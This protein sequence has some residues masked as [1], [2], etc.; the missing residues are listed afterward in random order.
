MTV[1]SD[2]PNRQPKRR[3]RP[4]LAPD[5]PRSDKRPRSIRLGDD[6]W[7]KLQRLGID[8]L[9]KSIDRAKEPE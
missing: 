1:E 4:A 3:G 9:E 6:R 8:W 5:A 2:L 7:A